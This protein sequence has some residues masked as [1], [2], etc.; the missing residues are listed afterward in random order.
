MKSIARITAFSL[1]TVLAL[2]CQDNQSAKPSTRPT[3]ALDSS[4]DVG[5][6][7]TEGSGGTL[8]R[9]DD[10]GEADA[11]AALRADPGMDPDRDKTAAEEQPS[12]DESSEAGPNEGD[13]EPP[14]GSEAASEP[15]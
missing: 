8:R 10:T 12:G 1:L 15:E 4:R 7:D 5:S 9:A 6:A 13:A 14:I 11:D 3:G 2:G